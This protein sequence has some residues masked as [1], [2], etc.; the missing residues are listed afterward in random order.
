MVGYEDGK[1]AAASSSTGRFRFF[2]GSLRASG[3]EAAR[4]FVDSS[5]QLVIF[6]KN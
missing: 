1:V 3:S 5:D 4:V 6:D 2:V